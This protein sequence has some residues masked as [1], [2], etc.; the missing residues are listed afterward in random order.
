MDKQKFVVE[1]YNAGLRGIKNTPYDGG[2]RVPFIICWPGGG[3]HQGKDIE[4]LT[5]NVDFMPTLLDLCGISIPEERSF[6]GKSVKPLL[7]GEH[8]SWEDRAM[9]TDSQRLTQPVKWRQ[10][11]V[12]T[13]RWRLINGEE[14]YDIQAGREQR[15]NIAEQ[16]PQI[17]EELRAEY[18]QWWDIVSEQ[19]D[20]EIPVSIG[21]EDNQT[22]CLT[23]HDWRSEDCV[24]PQQQGQVRQ[25]MKANGYW[26][27]EVEHAGEYVIELRRWPREANR[28][29][30][31]GVD[32]DDIEWR[33]EWIPEKNGIYTPAAMPCPL[34]KPN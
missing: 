20:E 6:H 9:V 27:I 34:K 29:I 3:I 30:T 2:H 13:I 24:M 17:V 12:M 31:L 14:L 28:E 25:G 7:Y 5:A 21:N 1:G 18:D 16:Y 4:E 11:A 22:I 33:K 8:D 26:E 15:Q 19:F 10:S 23:C 32:G